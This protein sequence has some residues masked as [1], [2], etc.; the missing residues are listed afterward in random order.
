VSDFGRQAELLG[1][2]RGA[3]LPIGREGEI[4]RL[5]EASEVAATVEILEDLF[6]KD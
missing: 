1:E 5:G 3:L 6:K 2:L 4:E